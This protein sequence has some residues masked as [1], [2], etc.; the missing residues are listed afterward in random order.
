M[1]KKLFAL[2]TLVYLIGCSTSDNSDEETA[3]ISKQA[4]TGSWAATKLTIVNNGGNLDFEIGQEYCETIDS[5]SLSFSDD[6]AG[7]E[8]DF[9]TTNLEFNINFLEIGLYDRTE[10][11]AYNRP[12][13]DELNDCEISYETNDSFNGFNKGSWELVGS[14]QIQLMETYELINLVSGGEERE[15]ERFDESEFIWRILA[16]SNTELKIFWRTRD[17]IDYEITFMKQ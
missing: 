4:L 16:F 14:E 5:S 9:C 2:F 17:Q 12:V 11:Y 3:N 6:C 1:L 7:I 10:V 8:L 13:I 15:V